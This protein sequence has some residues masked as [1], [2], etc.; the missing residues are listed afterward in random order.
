MLS[1]PIPGQAK[2]CSI[3][4]DPPISPGRL[5]PTIVI[6]GASALGKTCAR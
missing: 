3:R 4:T 5:R 2:T 6:N 1:V